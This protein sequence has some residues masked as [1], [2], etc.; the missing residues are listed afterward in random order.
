MKYPMRCPD[1]GYEAESKNVPI[2]Q[3]PPPMFCLLC[4]LTN[5]PRLV[6]MR[7]VWSA[8]PVVF[9]GGGWASKS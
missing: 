5:D 4:A 3:G 7:R 1:C 2:A 9:R 8:V 6:R